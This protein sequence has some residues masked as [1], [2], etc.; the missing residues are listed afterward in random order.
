MRVIGQIDCRDA[1]FVF[2][3]QQL[4][5]N[6]ETRLENFLTDWLKAQVRASKRSQIR[7]DAMSLEPCED[8]SVLAS[9]HSPRHQDAEATVEA[10]SE[11]L[12]RLSGEVAVSALTPRLGLRPASHE[13]GCRL[14]AARHCEGARSFSPVRAILFQ[15]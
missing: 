6:H 3:T 11:W 8:L 7:P 10:E 13:R 12:H 5:I 14:P 4:A 9:R 15:V 2:L 1:K